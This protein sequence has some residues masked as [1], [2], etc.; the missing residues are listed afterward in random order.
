MAEEELFDGTL[1]NTIDDDERIVFSKE[2]TP[3]AKYI[4]WL[5]FKALLTTLYMS[6]TSNQVVNGIKT[7]L[8]SPQV[9]DPNGP[10]D[11]VNLQTLLERTTD[12]NSVDFVPQN[13]VLS[14]KEGRM[15][16]D[17][18]EK[19]FSLFNDIADVKLDLGEELWARL[20]NNTGDILL[21]GKAGFV[22][23]VDAAEL[24]CD[25]A[26][27]SNLNQS[28]RALGLF[29]NNINDSA[30]GY[31]TRFGAVRDMDT[32]MWEVN[33]V[34]YLSPDIAG[35]LTNVRPKA[36][37]YPVRIG[38][39]IIKSPTVGVVGV[40]TLAFNGS[41]TT[42]N[43]EGSLNGIVIETPKCEFYESGGNIFIEVRNDKDLT[44]NLNFMI[45]SVRYELNTLSGG[46][47]NGGAFAQLTPGAD[48]E[49]LFE[50]FI[51]IWLN[52]GPPELRV[53]TLATPDK[54]APVG[55]CSIFNVARTLTE[56]VFKFRRYN[57]A[58]DNG[59][60]DG[61][62]R[63]IAD[64]IRDKLGTTYT[65]GIDATVTVN[66][67][68]SIKV[69]TT[70]GVGM[71]AHKKSFS[72]Q[73]GNSYWIYNDNT[74][75]AT[76]ELVTDLASIVETAIGQSL[77]VNGAYYRLPVYGMLNSPAGG[78]LG[79]IERLLVTRPLGFYS[80]PAEA[81]T[82][83]SNLDVSPNDI[84]TEGLLFE[85]YTLVIGRTGGGGAT[86]TEIAVIDDR[87]R[88]IKGGGGG[89]AQGGGGTDD[90]VRATLND[91]TN[92]YL[93]DKI[94]VAGNLQKRLVNPGGNEQIE[95]FDI[96][97][98]TVRKQIFVNDQTGSD[99]TGDG[100]V[101]L[102]YETALVALQ[103][104][105]K[106][107]NTVIEIKCDGISQNF[108]IA[109]VN[110]LES[111]VISETGV[112][113]FTGN[114]TKVHTSGITGVA[115]TLGT[116]D[117]PLSGQDYNHELTLR[118]NGSL[119]SMINFHDNNNVRLDY[120]N[121]TI[122]GNHEDIYQKDITISVIRLFYKTNLTNKI[123]TDKLE[124]TKDYLIINPNI[125]TP[126]IFRYFNIDYNYDDI[127]GDQVEH[128]YGSN[129]YYGCKVLNR[130]TDTITMDEYGKSAVIASS[131]IADPGIING[132]LIRTIN[133]PVLNECELVG[134]T[135]S[136]SQKAFKFQSCLIR[137]ISIS[138]IGYSSLLFAN[139]CSMEE[140]SAKLRAED[141]DYIFDVNSGN[142]ISTSSA[143]IITYS[144]VN[145]L[146]KFATL[147]NVD[148][149][150]REVQMDT[151]SFVIDIANVPQEEWQD[152]QKNVY[153]RLPGINLDETGGLLKVNV[154]FLP[155]GN[156][157]IEKE[158]WCNEFIQSGIIN[159][160]EPTNNFGQGASVLVRI[161]TDGSAINFP[162]GWGVVVNDYETP[163]AGTFGLLLIYDGALWQYSLYKINTL[164]E[165]L[166]PTLDAAVMG[167]TTA[168][169]TW[170]NITNNSGY[171]VYY[172]LQI[173]SVWTLFET[174]VGDDN[175]S[176]VTGLTAGL[177]YDFSII[178]KGDGVTY[179]DSIRSNI[180]QGTTVSGLVEQNIVPT[181]VNAN[182]TVTNGNDIE[183]T[184][185]DAAWSKTF[186]STDQFTVGYGRMT[187]LTGLANDERVILGVS[188]NQST[189]FTDM[190][191]AILVKPDTDLITIYESGVS[192]NA[193]VHSPAV[194]D[195]D[196][197]KI[198]VLGD[199]SVEYSRS[200]DGGSIYTVLYT[201]AGPVS[202][203]LRYVVGDFSETGGHQND[204]ILAK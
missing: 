164:T 25:L 112:L 6:L 72:A 121:T 125:S 204:I 4:P 197:Y 89:G 82:D 94:S 189:I 7:F 162:V 110:E 100:T 65:S 187:Y 133:N 10:T 126:I 145:Y 151:E 92:S 77:A 200:V 91:T 147:N 165:L 184:G 142:Y 185:G 132:F 56:G 179:S 202:N 180:V 161:I 40:D 15:Q 172:K 3:G 80:S 96:E 182:L 158:N 59:E 1:D 14:H 181:A 118:T 39:V 193:P 45:D 78:A 120:A 32:S 203:V 140:S 186:R 48:A 170:N 90:K 139:G 135:G 191:F 114:L 176:T 159:I 51:Y 24:E 157:L 201:N 85:L 73:D 128:P 54:N 8:L 44:K 66:S 101:G 27:A 169:L 75:V 192:V 143:S 23:G 31:I 11:A 93:N 33:D 83:A 137:R 131:M 36:P 123:Y 5:N 175:N 152:L 46:G 174:T 19:A 130:N 17:D 173:D 190:D 67:T 99:I 199:L 171:E 188:E 106:G 18:N 26:I 21:N 52:G 64:A 84:Q 107:I 22:S 20:K 63:W 194:A 183:K 177:D 76:Y 127:F 68:P 103:S 29:T 166:P 53:S 117:I 119:Y 124:M 134:G 115:N 42:V 97:Y 16:Y 108:D 196:I 71:Q 146:V 28:I 167:A 88:L 37:N 69:V 86:W 153:L 141:C 105:K 55:L 104:F 2:S 79:T 168:G 9:P 87:T 12:P 38:I 150:L 34:L 30:N 144:N 198:E 58:P 113:M 102:P 178:T 43:I 129:V 57:D 61:F 111:K 70:P 98:E 160:S 13:P 81:L 60:D 49:T 41:D 138:C 35:G 148:I 149:N 156:T 62:N 74:N 50:N 195:N 116:W 136:V 155:S 154:T 109:F 47:P 163:V 95:I 122:V